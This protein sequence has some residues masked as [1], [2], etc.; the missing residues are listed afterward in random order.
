MK[1]LGIA[2]RRITA[3]LIGAGLLCSRLCGLQAR[4]EAIRPQALLWALPPL[5]ATALMGAAVWA[6]WRFLF[7]DAAL[8]SRLW[9][10]V[11]VALC[12]AA[13][14][15]LYAVA[16]W[17]LGAIRREDLPARLRRRKA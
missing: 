8:Q 9:T 13:G 14:V 10:A 11:G 5:G 16:A 1:K 6:L 3:E 12:V 4:R 17:K 7:G 2:K 15:A